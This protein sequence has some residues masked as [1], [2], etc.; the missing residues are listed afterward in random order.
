MKI[1]T[2]LFLKSFLLSFLLFALISSIIIA[3]AYIEMVSLKPLEKESNILIG[4]IHEDQVISLAVLNFNPEKSEIAFVPIPDNTL[5]SENTILQDLYQ[6]GNVKTIVGK[7]EN[8]IGTNIDRYLLFST[9]AIRE[10]TNNVGKVNHYIP[11]K[12]IHEGTEF[13]GQ[14]NL[15]G[16]TAYSMF[17]Y[18]GYNL[19]EVSMSNMASSFLQS[20][21]SN[22]ANGTNIAKI[23]NS[24]SSNTVLKATNTNLTAEEIIAYCDYLADYSSLSHRFLEL[25]GTT[26]T[27]SKS[28]YFTPDELF[29]T[30]NIFK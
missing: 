6:N 29:T 26:Q 28:K 25:K 11:Y 27:T 21:L 24:L 8:L 10:L 5:V 14:S 18:S 23:K 17:T 3:S 20:F 30:K 12:F 19:K 4:I 15:S 22:H 9:E 2:Q 16:D 1:K 13:S 7:V